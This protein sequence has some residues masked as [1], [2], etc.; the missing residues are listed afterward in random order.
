MK[1]FNERELLEGTK[2]ET[3]VTLGK[4]EEFALISAD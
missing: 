1:I 3:I 2:T 4:T